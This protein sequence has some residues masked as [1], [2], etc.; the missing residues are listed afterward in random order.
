MEAGEAPLKEYM[1][2]QAWGERVWENG[3][4]PSGIL[5]Y[6]DRVESQEQFDEMKD[7]FNAQYSGK[8]NAGKKAF[9]T[10]NWNH[11]QL[12]VSPQEMQD[13]ER[14]RW[15]VEQIFLM[16]GVPLSVAGLR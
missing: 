13:I 6:Q 15:T 10:G 12:G 7:R 4:A 1:N 8:N 11:I 3:A 5:I 2:R 16:H 14:Q 9:L